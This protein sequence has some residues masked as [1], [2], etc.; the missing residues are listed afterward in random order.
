[1]DRPIERQINQCVDRRINWSEWRPLF[2]LT[3]NMQLVQT[4]IFTF[5]LNNIIIIAS[6]SAIARNYNVKVCNRFA[7][8]GQLSDDPE[9][10]WISIRGT[11]LNVATDIP[12]LCRPR[13]HA[14]GSQRSPSMPSTRRRRLGP[15]QST[16]TRSIEGHLQGH[17]NMAKDHLE[18]FFRSHNFLK[19]YIIFNNLITVRAI[20]KCSSTIVQRL[21]FGI[22]WDH[23]DWCTSWV[24]LTFIFQDQKCSCYALVIKYV[25]I[26]STLTAP[27]VE[28]LLFWKGDSSA[29]VFV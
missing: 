3:V 2:V 17:G 28:L 9:S 10:A 20:K 27:A 4:G 14:R 18:N 22:E 5:Q 26:P 25:D 21:I 15:K 16:W 6:N 23:C 1:M 29:A 19:S 13:K 8:P 12:A 11:I 7:A 24:T